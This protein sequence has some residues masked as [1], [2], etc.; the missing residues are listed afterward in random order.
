VSVWGHD[1]RPDFLSIVPSLSALD[2]IE[3]VPRIALTATAPAEVLG[4]I[5]E[6]LRLRDPHI[7]RRSLDRPNLHFSVIRC[8]NRKEKRA[9]LLRITLAHPGAP[10]I[11]YCPT[12]ATAEATAALLRGHGVVARHYHAGMPPEQREAVQEMFM[13]DHVLIICATNAFGLGVDKPNVAFVAHWAPP[14]SLDAYFQESGRAARDP[15]LRGNAVLLWTRSD[16]QLIRR[17]LNSTLPTIEDLEKLEREISSLAQPYVTVERLATRVGLDETSARV[18]INLLQR[19]GAIEQGADVGEQALL[20]IPSSVERIR[21][22]F[23][24]PIAK[25]VQEIT[26][27]ADMRS[28]PRKVV[29][30]LEVAIGLGVPAGDLD[31]ELRSLADQEVIGYRPFRR[32]MALRHVNPDWDHDSVARQLSRLKRSSYDRYDAM[33]AYATGRGCRRHR[34]LQHFGEDSEEACGNCDGCVGEP[35]VLAAV[36][37]IR[38]ADTDAITE[39]VAQSIISLV[40][41]ASRLGSAP[42]RGRFIKALKGVRRY[43]AYS[44]PEV[45]QRSRQFAA[46]AYMT[47]DE[48]S[49]AID[50]LLG[51]RRIIELEHRL[52]GGESYW[53]LDLPA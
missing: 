2:G 5:C 25:R 4:D 37:P 42:G 46:L 7:E 23:G 20:A 12:R 24:Q 52:S 36:D 47:E 35:S 31:L 11:V 45:L 6:Q 33:V 43:G 21:R 44:M 16:Q 29:D 41:E 1:F 50:T 34:I 51:Q 32:A 18:G 10:G 19:A 48:I 30:V 15:G 8:Q 3:N 28:M 13:A 53:G 27:A 40:R 49:E 14:F 22:R 39:Q 38:Y 17:L 9:Q 26:V